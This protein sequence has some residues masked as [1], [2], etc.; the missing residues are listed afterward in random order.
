FILISLTIDYAKLMNACCGV[1]AIKP[2]I[3][4]YNK[5]AN[6]ENAVSGSWS[7]QVSLQQSNG[8]HFCGGSL[9]STNWVLTAAHCSVHAVEMTSSISPI[10]LPSSFTNVLPGTRCV[11]T[12]WVNP[13]FL[14]QATLPIVSQAQCRQ[15]WGRNIITDAMI[16]AGASSCAGDSGGPLMC[17]SSGVWYQVGIVSWGHKSCKIIRFN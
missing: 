17:E 8:E 3:T 12:G 1:P 16:C 5:I 15:F 6:G 10:C 11:T 9:I 2:V 4:G 14:Q 13:R 7:W